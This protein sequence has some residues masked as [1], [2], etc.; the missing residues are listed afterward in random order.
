MDRRIFIRN[1]G[2]GLGAVIV[3]NILGAEK[4]NKPNSI[5][6]PPETGVK[7]FNL[8][9]AGLIRHTKVSEI[10]DG[11]IKTKANGFTGVYMLNDYIGWNWEPDG[12]SGFD[13]CW[14]LYNIFDFTFS[15]KKEKYQAYLRELC[16][17]CKSAGLDIYISFW[18]PMIGKEMTE[19][20]KNNT[21][22]GI[23]SGIY[24]GKPYPTF[25]TCVEGEGL[26][27]LGQMVEILM[28]TFPQIKGLIIATED[29]GCL[30]CDDSCP[31][32][33]GTVRSDHVANMYETI[34]AYMNK[35]R[36]DAQ[37]FVYPWY[38]K[39][40]YFEKV[41]P[42]LKKDYYVVCRLKQF[43]KQQLE[44]EI[45]SGPLQ[46]CH[47]VS[48][49]EGPEI[50]KW[51]HKVG[52]SRIL[53]MTPTATSS[54][55]WFLAAPPHPG[56]LY[57][58]LKLQSDLGINKFL[59]YDCGSHIGG[60]SNEDAIGIFN[61]QPTITE[62]K[63]L[64][65]LAA[66]RYANN[67]ARELSIQGWKAFDKGFGYIPMGLGE[68]KSPNWSERFGFGWTLC[69]ST[70][71]IPENFGADD[72]M[73]DFFWFSPYNFFRPA[74]A[75]RIEIQFQKMVMHWQEA[76]MCLQSASILEGNTES[77]R[78]AHAALA[79]LMCAESALHFCIGASLSANSDNKSFK[80]LLISEIE[81]TTKFNDFFKQHPWVYDNSC[82]H[83]QF[84]P[85]AQRK[86]WGD[87]E[88]W[89]YGYRNPFEAKI[90]VMTRSL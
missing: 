76:S 81:L 70:P 42:R 58:H 17:A 78:D 27:V 38:W 35:V 51:I 28:T 25:C 8:A 21:K 77:A 44:L 26:K 40:G 19:Y 2:L 24:E 3:T 29:N 65:T 7:H 43:S 68:T 85:L 89:R 11:L 71:I 15:K 87:K 61:Q 59:D 20:L 9:I 12:D 30:L 14:R 62:D 64:E 63:L 74:T 16:E 54:D 57:R 72:R 4:I 56:R 13:G 69:M 6:L 10:A 67:K 52:A 66:K 37:L 82:W 53:D 75:Q 86:T 50:H 47:I 49:K 45:P 80:D 60:T 18:M 23:G 5:V 79:H 31:N 39:E 46:D 84:T 41:L 73:H 32:A 83:P 55:N 48:E 34:E 22:K 33:H 88:G 1:S 36:S 90:E